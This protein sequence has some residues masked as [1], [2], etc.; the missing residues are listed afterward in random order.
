MTIGSDDIK[1]F[2]A[3]LEKCGAEVLAPT[4]EFELMRVRTVEGTMVVHTNK[5]GAQKWPARLVDLWRQF[6]AGRMTPKLSPSP[7]TPLSGNRKGR[8]VTLINRDGNKCWYCNRETLE[9]GSP[10]AVAEPSREATV[11]EICPRQHGGPNH[12]ANQ[13]VACGA[14]NRQAGNLPVAAKVRLREIL[15]SETNF[16]QTDV[17]CNWREYDFRAAA[18]ALGGAS[19]VAQAQTERG[20]ESVLPASIKTASGLL[21]HSQAIDDKEKIVRMKKP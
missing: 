8:L 19:M 11:E 4:T 16:G 5:R 7:A 18:T 9:P 2:Q 3:W 12:V 13:V 17:P 15:R 20:S 14:C 21:L 6:Q 1:R 10:A